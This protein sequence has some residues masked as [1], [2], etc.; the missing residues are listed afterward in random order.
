MLLLFVSKR[1]ICILTR[2]TSIRRSCFQVT[3]LCP[4]VGLAHS[5]LQRSIFWQPR[6]GGA[7]VLQQHLHEGCEPVH[8]PFHPT[9]GGLREHPPRRRAVQGRP[10]ASLCR[11]LD[12]LVSSLLFAWLDLERISSNPRRNLPASETGLG[13]LKTIR[14]LFLPPKVTDTLAFCSFWTGIECHGGCG[15]V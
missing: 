15:Y 1:T 14:Y 8:R 6:A 13:G 9:R 10:G 5:W 4:H 7:R 2:P 11:C 12:P 3:F